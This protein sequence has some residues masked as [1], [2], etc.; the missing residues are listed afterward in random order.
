MWG[1]KMRF[2]VSL[3]ALAAT[4]VV[5]APAAAATA[6]VT[7]T[8]NP[9]AKGVVVLPLTLSKTADLD[10]GTV[11]ASTTTP[12]S[13][14]ISADDGSRAVTGGVIGVP[15]Y[16]GNR[17]VFQGAGTASQNVLLTLKAPA[18]LS[19][20]SNTITVSS[21]VFDSAATSSNNAVTGYL[22][23]TRTINGTGAFSIGVGG[24]FAIAANQANGLYSAPFIVTAEYQ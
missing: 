11:I 10:F 21:M 13:V 17:A 16:P 24:T 20:G 4:L 5:A 18:V 1:I 22:E 14:S 6:T 2:T 23:T 7:A 12:G 3:A 19:N 15:N 9:I 8:G